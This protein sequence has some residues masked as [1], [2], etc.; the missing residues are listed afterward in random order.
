MSKNMNTKTKRRGMNS[1]MWMATRKP[2]DESSDSGDDSDDS[3]NC[4]N[5]DES[6]YA[7]F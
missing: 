4:E 5:S 1:W 2:T 3:E 7:S 6:G